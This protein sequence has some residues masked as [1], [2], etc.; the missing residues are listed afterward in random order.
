[1]QDILNAK[2]NHLNKC[3]DADDYTKKSDKWNDLDDNTM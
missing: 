3:H 2:K 1:M